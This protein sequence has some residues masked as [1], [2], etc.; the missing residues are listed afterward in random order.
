[1]TW[2]AEGDDGYIAIVRKFASL[3]VELRSL[4]AELPA[5]VASSNAGNSEFYTRCVE[6]GYRQFW[7][8]YCATQG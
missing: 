4:R 2:V 1:M 8:R 7:R 6:A 3:P 5:R